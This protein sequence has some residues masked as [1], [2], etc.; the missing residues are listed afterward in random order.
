MFS[1]CNFFIGRSLYELNLME[2]APESGFYRITLSVTASQQSAVKLIGTSGAEVCRQ[3]C[4][5]FCGE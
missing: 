3:C 1:R 2:V 5:L 4:I